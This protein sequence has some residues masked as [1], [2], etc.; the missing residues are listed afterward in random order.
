LLTVSRTFEPAA[1]L[2]F[3]RGFWEITF[4]DLTF[5][6]KALLIFPTLQR[7]FRIAL[8]A[9][10]SRLPVTLGTTQRGSDAKVAVAE[11]SAVRLIVHAPAPEHAPDH[12]VKV[13]PAAGLSVSVSAAP[14]GNGCE[15]A[16]PQSIPA[17]VEVTA[18]RPLPDVAT[19]NVFGQRV[20][21]PTLTATGAEAI[22]FAITRR[23]DAPWGMQAGSANFDEEAAPGAIDLFVIPNVRAY[24]TVSVALWVIWT[25]G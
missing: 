5:A 13:D 15:Q 24:V 19:V 17:G 3:G 11:L 16:E 22:P 14:S 4:P 7:A 18:P 23:S 25:S 20:A 8:L 10:V 12:P 21:A 6:E 2:V 1:S 9:A